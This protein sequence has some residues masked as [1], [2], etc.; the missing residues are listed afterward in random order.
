MVLLK[1]KNLGSPLSVPVVPLVIWLVRVTSAEKHVG[2]DQNPVPLANYGV[3]TCPLAN[4]GVVTCH[5]LLID[6][7]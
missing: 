3:V 2:M 7:V 6:R 1:K 4:Y 5:D